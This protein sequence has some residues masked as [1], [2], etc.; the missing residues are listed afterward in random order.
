MPI[1]IGPGVGLESFVFPRFG[2]LVSR[3]NNGLPTLTITTGSLSLIQTGLQDLTV[4][5]NLGNTV[6]GC[7]LVIA[8]TSK[9]TASGQRLT[10]VGTSG[11]TTVYAT[12]TGYNDSATITVTSTGGLIQNMVVGVGGD[13]TTDGVSLTSWTDQGSAAQTWTEATFP[14][15]Y[16]TGG[17][18]GQPYVLFNGTDQF[19]SSPSTTAYNVAGDDQFQLICL[20]TTADS[21]A[22]DRAVRTSYI[23]TPTFRGSVFLARTNNSVRLQ[24][25]TGA[26]SN[27][28]LTSSANTI[29]TANH[30]YISGVLRNN[31]ALTQALY[32]NGVSAATGTNTFRDNNAAVVHRLG[33]IQAGGSLYAGMQ[34]YNVKKVSRVPTATE[35]AQL[36][37]AAATLMGL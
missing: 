13:T 10:G 27:T 8:D 7:T 4:Q 1:G 12:K 18:N 2:P 33:C 19:L 35:I 22:S 3:L 34:L 25:G 24:Y 37:L 16:K 11:T 28:T 23:D 17:V 20:K 14:P 26:A 15:T 29:L 31:G 32:I 6:T 9:C 5:D 36:H 21:P 30:Y